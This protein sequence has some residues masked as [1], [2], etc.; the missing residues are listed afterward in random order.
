MHSARVQAGAATSAPGTATAAERDE[1]RIATGDGDVVLTVPEHG[2]QAPAVLPVFDGPLR[3]KLDVNT[4]QIAKGELYWNKAF[5]A[6]APVSLPYPR[7]RG[8]GSVPVRIAVEAPSAGPK[9]VAGVCWHGQSL[10]YRELDDRATAM[11]VTT[12][13]LAASLEL[14]APSVFLLDRVQPSA[15]PAA[16]LPGSSPDGAAY[17]IYTSG[18]TG[19][20]KG[21]VV[22]NR[23]VM[24]LFA[25]MAGRI[26]HEMMGRWLAI[27]S[28][29]FDIS[30]LEL[31]WTLAHGFSVVLHSDTVQADDPAPEFSLF[32]FAA[33]N[34]RDPKD[35]YKLL[36][37]GAKFADREGFA[38]I[39]TPER[40]FHAFGGLCPNPALTSATIA[41][42]TTR[43][44][45]RAGSCVLPLHHPI[46]VAEE[47]AFVADPARAAGLAHR[48]RQPRD[49]PAGRG[50]G[51]GRERARRDSRARHRGLALHDDGRA[52]SLVADRGAAP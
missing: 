2:L 3:E 51:L 21:V 6:L 40:H 33:D 5:A 30:A 11:V 47:W 26:P 16:A 14:D 37:E 27:T 24:N 39:W 49:L 41:A 8:A 18:S 38:A 34:A 29:S 25:G 23:N 45:I 35:R 4:P 13:A 1:L 31:C 32:Y 50:A 22:T 44:Q 9:T 36:L 52:G 42:I 20:P 7:T 43:L 19:H 17:V 15:G 46:R 48:R 28:L 10:T 12:L